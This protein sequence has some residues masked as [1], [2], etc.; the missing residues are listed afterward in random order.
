MLFLFLSS[1]FHTVLW[2]WALNAARDAILLLESHEKKQDNRE[3][4]EKKGGNN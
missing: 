1:F 4:K 2:A 3:T